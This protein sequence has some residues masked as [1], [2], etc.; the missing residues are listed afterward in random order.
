MPLNLKKAFNERVELP[1]HVTCR[2]SRH[3]HGCARDLLTY[4]EFLA[5]KNP[6]RFVIASVPELTKGCNGKYRKNKKPYSQVTVEKT[7]KIFRD[8]G[9]ISKRIEMLFYGITRSGFV[10]A[11]HDA[12]VIRHPKA[13]VFTGIGAGGPGQFINGI[14]AKNTLSANWFGLIDE[15]SGDG[16]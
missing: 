15:E 11:P 13:C 5:T 14:W 4:I 3:V 10:A 1:E 6:D 8:R 7:L 16:Q 2:W 12:M 9:I